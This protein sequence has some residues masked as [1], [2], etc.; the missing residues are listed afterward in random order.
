MKILGH[1]VDHQKVVFGGAAFIVAGFI[2]AVDTLTEIEGAIAVLYVIALMLG[3]Q[4]VGRLGIISLTIA[5]VGLALLSYAVTHETEND[6]QTI[7][8]L[9]VAI[10]ALGVTSGLLLRADTSRQELIKSNSALRESEARYRSIF[11]RTRVALWERDYSELR[12]FL[13]VLRSSGVSD[14]SAYAKTH[15]DFISSCFDMIKIVAANDAAVELIGPSASSPGGGFISR[16]IPKDSEAFVGILQAIAEGERH[17]EDDAEVI[18]DDGQRKSVIISISFPD[19]PAAFNRVVLSMVDITHREEARKALAEAQV[20]LGKAS[21]IATVGVLSASLAHELN[22]PLGAIG[23]NSQTL[24]R[25]LDRSPP[26]L[27]AAKR[28]AERIL[29]DSARASDIIMNTRSKLTSA[30]KEPEPIAIT[31]LVRDTLTLMEHDLQRDGISVEVVERSSMP[32]FYGVKLE[33]QQVLINLISNAAQSISAAIP[34]RRLVTIILDS[35]GYSDHLSIAVRDTGHGL[36]SDIQQKIFTPFFTTKETGMG[37]GLAFCRS[38]VE[39]IGGT[40]EG[41]NHPDGGALF[42]IRLPKD[43]VDVRT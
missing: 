25:W 22:Q 28:S 3:A 20:E 26:D 36:I 42:E 6:P 11:D 2:F 37:M 40:L 14:F 34:E 19:D 10:A 30:A 5:F 16:F 12:D 18:C 7:L 31:A 27:D 39:A 17:F 24:I 15:P 33:M 21:K 8:R 32:S 38:A 1:R 35:P 13:A 23:V 41:K 4:A 43:A 29:R 9:I